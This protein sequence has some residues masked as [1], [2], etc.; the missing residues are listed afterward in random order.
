M[1]RLGTAWYVLIATALM[2]GQP[3]VTTLTQNERGTYDYLVLST[4]LLGECVKLAVS[5]LAYAALPPVRRTHRLLGR[6]DVLAFVAPA[7]VYALNNA[8]VFEIVA[9]I[10]PTAFQVLS[11]SKTVFTAILFRLVLRRRLTATQQTAIVMLAAGAAVSRLGP[12]CAEAGSGD[13]AAPA[14]EWLGVLLTL[15]SCVASSLGGVLNEWLLK[16]DGTL[17]AL[18]LQNALLYA[19]GVLINVVAL[20][21]RDHARLAA[22]GLVAGYTPAVALMIAA[23]AVTGLSISA[24]LKHGDNL[25]RVFAHTC[26][27]LLSMALEA[28]VLAVAPTPQLALAVVIVTGSALV[29]ARDGAPA[30]PKPD[31]VLLHEETPNEVAV[32]PPPSSKV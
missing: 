15:V 22:G 10:R 8:L 23:N 13:E 27:M 28:A 14:T 11:S 2:T 4:V 25:L 9:H 21:V 20:G 12:A 16:K 1:R 17:H 32:A 7:L 24:V 6:R 29:Y 31:P 3:V 26:A 19:W 5:L 30:S 18:C